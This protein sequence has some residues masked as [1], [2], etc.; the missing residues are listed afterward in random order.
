M[1][2]GFSEETIQFMWGIRF[3]NRRDWFLEQ[4]PVYLRSFYEPLKELA[5]EV[6]KEFLRK[7]Q[8]L[9]LNVKVTRIYRDARRVKYGGLYKDH[10]WFILKP[11][12]EEFTAAP[13]FYFEVRPEGYEIGM[14]YW[15]PKPSMMEKFRRKA[16]REPKKLEKLA[17]RLN[18]QAEFVLEG[19]E[20]KRPKGEV[21]PLLQPWFNRKSIGICKVQE[22]TEDCPFY[23]RELVEEILSGFEWLLPFYDYFK[24]LDF[25][26]DI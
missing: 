10:L 14:G 11:F 16:L 26:P 20:Y 12:Q 22:Y 15:C 19:E 8:N 17:R 21:S 2:Q 4:K 7:H 25:E 3:N 5:A 1:F 23:S 24:E 9:E 6:Q 18:N 13:A